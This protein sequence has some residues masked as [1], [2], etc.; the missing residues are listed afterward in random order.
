MLKSRFSKSFGFILLVLLVISLFFC[1]LAMGQTTISFKL[2]LEVLT[3]YDPSNTEHL[4]VATSRLSRAVIALCIGMSLAIAGVL[5]QALTRNPLASP[6][7]LGINAGAI[8]FI[9][10]AITWLNIHSLVGYM[11]FAFLGAA[12]SG[13]SVFLLSNFG[14]DGVTPLKVIIAGTAL[15]ALFMSFTQGMLV[16]D[17]QS[18]QTVLFWL[19]GSIAGRDLDMLFS[20]LPLLILALIICLFLG[21]SVN[22]FSAGEDIA[23][24]LG[25]NVVLIK[26]LI[27]LIIIILAGGSVAVVGSVGFIGLIVPHMAKALVGIDYRWIIPYSALI[28]SALLIAADV[29]ARFIISPMEVP[30]GVM[31]A[32]IGG[33]FF[34][35]L[36]KK[37]V[38]KQ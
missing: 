6:D 32:F 19:A 16:I 2:A 5:I 15:S 8:F 14:R 28:G 29:A 12:I 35:Y 26:L 23:K 17:E 27:G 1:S 25:Q 22:V 34:I 13:F 20:V 30:I 36:A 9:V 7:L 21:K 3:N 38:A 10:F 24:S 18:M 33:P 11:W 4:V 37:G 31:T